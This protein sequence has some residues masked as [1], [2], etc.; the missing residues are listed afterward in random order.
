MVLITLNRAESPK[1][2]SPGQRPGEGGR[3]CDALQGQ[4][5]VWRIG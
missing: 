5:Q 4:K 1:A 2:Y 3:E